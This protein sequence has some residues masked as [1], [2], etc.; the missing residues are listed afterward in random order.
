M[1]E[2]IERAKK[3]LKDW[4]G[5]SYTF[6]ENVLDATG[7]YAK[8]YGKKAALVVTELGQSWIEKPV[9]QVKA[10]LKANGVSF[11]LINGA[12]PNAPREDVY[13]I[14]HP[15]GAVQ[16]GRHRCSGRRKHDRCRQGCCCP[17][18][19]LPV[20]SERDPWRES[21][22]RRFD[23]ALF[24]RG[25]RHQGQGED[26]QVRDAGRRRRDGCQL[27]GPSD[28]VFE[29]YGPGHGT[30]ETDRRRGHRSSLIGL[31]F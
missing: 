16:S 4:K 15:G 12:R 29:H 26:G 1:K 25:N 24:W 10:S 3:I 20:R 19:L 8:Q 7:K 21:G 2:N 23:R 30:E 13:R 17:E 28:Q 14:S 27:R 31:R 6:G 11:E 22:G 9:E 18:H 5:D